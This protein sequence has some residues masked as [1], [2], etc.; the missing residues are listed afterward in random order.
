MKKE[1]KS[2]KANN[3]VVSNSIVKVNHNFTRFSTVS[4]ELVL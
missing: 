3:V 1:N 2:L 4:S